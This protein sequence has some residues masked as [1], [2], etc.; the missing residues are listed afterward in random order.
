VLAHLHWRK[1]SHL[2][3]YMLSKTASLQPAFQLD[4]W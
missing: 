1:L 4:A 2:I 3:E